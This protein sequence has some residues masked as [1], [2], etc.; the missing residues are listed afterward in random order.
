MTISTKKI[1][2]LKAQMTALNIFEDDI[3]EKFILGSGQGGQKI[4]KTSSCVY[5]KHLPTGFEVKCQQG[6][7]RSENRFYAR[8]RLCD[9]IELLMLQE[10]SRI[11]QEIEKIRRQK[12]RRSRKA[13]RKV[14][15]E[16]TQ[17]SAIKKT[18]LPP[19]GSE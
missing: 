11:Q 17:R 16:K 4:N 12:Q 15:E 10:K 13:Q 1:V 7:L 2:Q 8:R 6:R 9:K 18:R 14:R 3:E 5:L 19:S